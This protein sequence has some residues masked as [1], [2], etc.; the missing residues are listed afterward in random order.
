M[1]YLRYSL[2]LLFLKCC[3]CDEIFRTSMFCQN[4]YPEYFTNPNSVKILPYQLGYLHRVVH[5]LDKV[6]DRHN[7]INLEAM[8]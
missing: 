2:M 3:C 4:N 8:F 7:D 5:V 1:C 6:Y